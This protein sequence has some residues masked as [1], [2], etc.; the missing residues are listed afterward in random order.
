MSA[1]ANLTITKDPIEFGLGLDAGGTATRWALVNKNSEVLEQ[2]LVRGLTGLLMETPEGRSELNEV[3]HRI[4]TQAFGAR[5]V[6]KSKLHCYAGFTGLPDDARLFHAQCATALDLTPSQL[7]LD[8]D[9]ALTH[10]ANF[11][12]GEGIVVYAGT[13]SY[14]SFLDAEGTLHRTGAR[15]GIL[16]DGGSGFWIARKALSH[17]WRCEDERP[18]QWTQ[19]DMARALFDQLGGSDWSHTRQFVYGQSNA[20]MRGR[21][22][23]LATAVGA[24][25]DTDATANKILIEAGLELA[26][27]GNILCDQFGNHP[28][29]F[30][31]RVFN[32]HP[33]ILET[34]RKNINRSN[35]NSVELSSINSIAVAAARIALK[36]LP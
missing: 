2:G 36:R 30:A 24:S 26:R 9:I 20:Q 14:A 19:S 35:R 7:T 16:D 4:A 1:D 17:V 8:S 12:P 3:L 15:G 25:A 33:I 29:I 27:L 13:G 11:R 34:A 5:I 10:S 28:I 21:M 31:G 32:L 23:V 18:G 22:G 6:V